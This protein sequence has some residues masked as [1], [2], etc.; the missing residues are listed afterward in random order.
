MMTPTQ[1]AY[2]AAHKERQKRLGGNG[3]PE[4]ELA[5]RSENE[6]RLD[7]EVKKLRAEILELRGVIAEQKRLLGDDGCKI[8][9]PQIQKAVCREFEISLHEML[10]SSRLGYITVARQV[11]YYLSRKLSTLS[12]VQ[13]GLRF[14]RDH[15]SVINGISKIEEM[16]AEDAAFK[17]RLAGIAESLGGSL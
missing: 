3:K 14:R 6:K 4:P 8:T 15:A 10:S 11:G 16:M 12:L 9:V 1:A 2:H 17:E 5:F 7:A 13:V